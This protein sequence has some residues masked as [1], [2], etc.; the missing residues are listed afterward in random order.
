MS[1]LL[2]E[3]LIDFDHQTGSFSG[4]SDNIREDWK[5]W[6]PNVNHELELKKAAG[7]LM[8][9]E[10]RADSNYRNFL[11]SW[12]KRSSQPKPWENKSKCPTC[13]K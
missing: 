11:N 7:W 1:E 2:E 10:P 6:A 12:M 4:I 13:G 3:Q 8:K 5:K 9:K